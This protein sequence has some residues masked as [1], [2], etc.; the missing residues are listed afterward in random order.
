MMKVFS[1]LGAIDQPPSSQQKLFSFQF[2]EDW[3]PEQELV[4]ASASQEEEEEEDRND[5][6]KE[7]EYFDSDEEEAK[8][9]EAAILS[10]E[11]SESNGGVVDKVAGK[12]TNEGEV[13]GEEGEEEVGYGEEG[14]ERE[15]RE[16]GE[17]GEERSEEGD[18]EAQASH[19]VMKVN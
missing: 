8:R 17:E 7:L 12:A 1:V 2:K 18:E 9:I 19:A 16:E 15:E 14:E 13:K 6:E 5:A 3:G 10:D 4:Y 11:A